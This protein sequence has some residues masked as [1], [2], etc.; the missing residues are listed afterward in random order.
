MLVVGFASSSICSVAL[1]L[2][3][4]TVNSWGGF[5]F[6]EPVNVVD[7]RVRTVRC[8]GGGSGSCDGDADSAVKGALRALEAVADSAVFLGLFAGGEFSLL[9]ERGG[10]MAGGKFLL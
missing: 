6:V 7:G 2:S 10:G 8:S 4:N 3:V 1:V 5:A 9:D